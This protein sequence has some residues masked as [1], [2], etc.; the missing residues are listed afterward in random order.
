MS[1]GL[2]LAAESICAKRLEP[3]VLTVLDHHGLRLNWGTWTMQENKWIYLGLTVSGMMVIAYV[4]YL[5]HV[6]LVIR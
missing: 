3:T 4:A 6:G 5:F 2:I 1:A